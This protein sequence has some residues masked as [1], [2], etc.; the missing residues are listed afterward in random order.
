VL[1]THQ[2]KKKGIVDVRDARRAVDVQ[3]AKLGT[4]VASAEEDDNP[5]RTP[6]KAKMPKRDQIKYYSPFSQ[7]VLQ[8]AKIEFRRLIFTLD[9]FPDDQVRVRF[10]KTAWK[11]ACELKPTEF[12][13]GQ[14]SVI[15]VFL[16]LNVPSASLQKYD[17]YILRIV[18]HLTCRILL[19]IKSPPRPGIWRGLPGT[20]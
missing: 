13:K 1:S 2:R 9:G 8:Q 10:G 11:N 16:S 4:P 14:C 15:T 5:R 7:T 6:P 18:R 20:T 12:N 17:K 3:A 19:S